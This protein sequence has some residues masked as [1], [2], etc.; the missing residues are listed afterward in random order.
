MMC[1]RRMSPHPLPRGEGKLGDP[2]ILSIQGR[3]CVMPCHWSGLS[4]LLDKAAYAP[5]RED[6]TRRLTASLSTGPASPDLPDLR[7]GTLRIQLSIHS[8]EPS[9]D[10]GA[11]RADALLRRRQH[12]MPKQ[13]VSPSKKAHAI[14]TGV[15]QSDP[16]SASD[17]RTRGAGSLS[18]IIDGVTSGTLSRKDLRIALN[19]SWKG[20]QSLNT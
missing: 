7:T 20:T 16:G 17:S 5:H 18:T 4:Q 14:E 12:W 1:R 8:S 3:S 11:L 13:T 10:G 9:G 6:K 15:R 19:C 2:D